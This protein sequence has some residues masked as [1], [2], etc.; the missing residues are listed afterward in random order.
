MQITSKTKFLVISPH[1]D[2]EAL[3]AGGLI[4][5]ALREKAKVMIYYLTAG[6]SR[7]L[8]TGQTDSKTRL[9]EIES[10]KKLTGA[11][12]KVEYVGEEF[13]RL[14][15]VPQKDLIEHI[16]DEI[17][18][19]K[20]DIVAIPAYYSYNQDHRALYEACITALRP[21]PKDIRHH[22]SAVLEYGEPYVWGVKSPEA[23]NVYLDL[24]QKLGKGNLFDFKIKLY[25]CHKTQ[26]RSG[27]FSRSIE[28]LKHEAHI[29][30]REIGI[31]LAESYRLLRDEI[32]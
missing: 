25:K 23:H 32:C 22:V 6:N 5:K 31:E 28:N 15:T 4:G 16:E 27:V 13:C 9:K 7:Q 30:G 18:G 29:S 17:A 24:S 26:V 11:K 1:P 21:I 20:P 19:F 8:V 3:G 12:I 14:D 2:D 10:V